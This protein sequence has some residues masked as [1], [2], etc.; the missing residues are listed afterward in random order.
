MTN[1]NMTL[2]VSIVAVILIVGVSGWYFV[3]SK[4]ANQT[5]QE[6]PDIIKNDVTDN[7]TNDKKEQVA[8]TPVVKEVIKEEPETADKY[9]IESGEASYTATKTY[10]GKPG[11]EVVGKSEVVKG[12]GWLD[13]EAKKGYLNVML[14][15]SDF[16]T[17]SSKRDADIAPLFI[18]KEI[19]LS[20]EINGLENMTIGKTTK[21]KIPLALTINQIKKDVVFEVDVMLDKAGV[22]TAK[23]DAKVM[24]TDFNIKTPSLVN[25]F[26]V[27]DEVT[28]M[29]D[30]KGQKVS[31]E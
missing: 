27:D 29:F 6:M 2:T 3:T 26:S 25:V 14:N 24:M 10:F 21:V 12:D 7:P 31:K 9:T 13:I 15:F 30:V 18:S 16:K 23:G 17:A 20:G 4:S 19:L 28:L 22:V 1:K 8:E 5:K 11:E